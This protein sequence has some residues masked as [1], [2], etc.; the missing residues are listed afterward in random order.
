MRIATLL[1]AAVTS[2]AVLAQTIVTTAPQNAQ[3]AYY[4]LS[5]G[6]VA[7]TALADWDLAF[8]LTGITGSILLNTA[9]GH[10]LYKAPY[11][12]AQWSSIDTTGLGA[13]WS[14][15]HNSETDWSS[16]AFNQGLT[17]NPF[18]LGWGIYNFVTHN[19]AGDSCFVLKLST[20]EWKKLRID[21]FTATTNSFSFTWADL[22]GAN[23]QSGSLVRSAYP[24]KN[25]GYYNLITNT[26]LDLEPLAADWDLLFT[27]YMAF[28]TQP[29]P[30][31]YPVAGVLQNRM[32]EAV[33]IDGV[34]TANATYWGETFDADMDVLGYDWK[35]FNQGT[36]QWE[37]AQD[38][39]YFVKDR[40]GDIW[41]I[42]FVSY[43][44]SAN[45]NFTF[46][47]ELV[48]EASVDETGRRSALAIAPNPSV[49]TMNM[50]IASKAHSAQLSIIDMNGRVVGQESLTGLSGLVQRPIDVSALPA[51]L[52]LVRVQGDG[53]DVTVRL[54]KE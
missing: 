19:I 26:A 50:I 4:S 54:V 35:N 49:G 27:K 16:G 37:Y 52:Y 48:G 8:E 29:F 33:Q 36:F 5:N 12:L 9:K 41:K 3:Q 2:S 18:D 46:N 6:V 10:K 31:F 42:V 23:E 30:A 40:T 45:G 1:A 28:V 17:A 38:R 32:V 7:S 22:D 21:G 51:G 34:P 15:Q 20:G 44:G 39:T 11:T 25:F 13:S 43:G 47:Q 14:Q 24:G 53:L